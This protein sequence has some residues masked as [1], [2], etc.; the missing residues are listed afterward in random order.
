MQRLNSR[1]VLDSA[2]S[3]GS[4]ESCVDGADLCGKDLTCYQGVCTEIHCHYGYEAGL[5]PFGQPCADCLAPTEWASC[6][7]GE[8]DACNGIYQSPI[9]IVTSDAFTPTAGSTAI[10]FSYAPDSDREIINTGHNFEVILSNAAGKV[11]Y[12]ERDY[13]ALQFHFH[14]LSEHT[15]DGAYYVSLITLFHIRLANNR[16]GKCT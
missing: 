3:L 1:N 6:P 7:T 14:L 15:V 13:I 9:N 4:N 5:D 10:D 12:E 2:V 16:M 11:R 8:W